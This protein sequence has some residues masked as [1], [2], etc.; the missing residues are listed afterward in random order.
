MLVKR[1]NKETKYVL[2]VI[3]KGY[4]KNFYYES[5]NDLNKAYRQ[6]KAIKG[7]I[8]PSYPIVYEKTFVN[9]ET[10]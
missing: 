2:P 7:Y 8:K 9:E 1:S 3:I 4:K 5:E 10:E 6:L